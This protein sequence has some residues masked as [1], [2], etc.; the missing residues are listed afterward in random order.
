MR[1]VMEVRFKIGTTDRIGSNFAEA[2]ACG[3]SLWD[4]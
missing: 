4:S 3:V 1:A 2:T